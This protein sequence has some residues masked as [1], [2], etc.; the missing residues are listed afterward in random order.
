MASH[1]CLVSAV[2]PCFFGE[3]W[4]GTMRWKPE[5]KELDHGRYCTYIKVVCSCFGGAGGDVVP[6][7][8]A[9]HSVVHQ[10]TGCI[11]FTPQYITVAKPYSDIHLL[12]LHLSPPSSPSKAKS[13][14][15]LEYLNY[16]KP[17]S[18][19]SH[20]AWFTDW[21]HLNKKNTHTFKSAVAPPCTHI[22]RV[23]FFFC[24]LCPT[25]PNST[26]PFQVWVLRMYATADVRYGWAKG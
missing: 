22:C 24:A 9:S 6:V 23:F 4:M 16:I 19:S 3:G 18:N 8:V 13:S 1:N 7:S 21:S 5:P 20:T 10:G 11:L 12:E 2:I 15:S 25:Q 17:T 14:C 26:Q